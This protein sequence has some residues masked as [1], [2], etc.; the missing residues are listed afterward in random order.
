MFPFEVF[1]VPLAA[2]QADLCLLRH[3]TQK[4]LLFMMTQSL[5]DCKQILH[6]CVSRCDE[7]VYGFTE[8]VASCIQRAIETISVLGQRAEQRS[9]FLPQPE[10][11]YVEKDYEILLEDPTTE[12]VQTPTME[13]YLTHE[14]VPEIKV[15][16]QLVPRD[17]VEDPEIKVQTQIVLHDP[18]EDIE[19]E[20]PQDPDFLA[21]KLF[22][23]QAQID[24]IPTK[25]SYQELEIGESGQDSD[26]ASEHE[27]EDEQVKETVILEK[28]KTKAEKRRR[29]KER[30][31]LERQREKKKEPEFQVIVQTELSIS[32]RTESARR[33]LMLRHLFGV[34]S[35]DLRIRLE[36]IE[37]TIEHLFNQEGERK[38]EMK[39]PI[40]SLSQTRINLFKDVKEWAD[41]FQKGAL[42]LGTFRKFH[43]LCTETRRTIEE[44]RDIFVEYFALNHSED[45][46]SFSLQGEYIADFVYWTSVFK[47]CDE[48]IATDLL[49]WQ[50]EL[51]Q[52]WKEEK[53]KGS[54]DVSFYLLLERYNNVM[55]S[56]C[57]AA[58]CFCRDENCAAKL[59]A[60][61]ISKLFRIQ[62][63]SYVSH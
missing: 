53:R 62:P 44:N 20:D 58:N 40:R 43:S 9:L 34:L 21:M 19:K 49:K 39:K 41:C 23:A 29:Y 51:Q 8:D 3:K 60:P 48:W 33:L 42:S 35:N 36:G 55:G 22:P 52:M 45:I 46:I 27:N 59:V 18:E 6:H 31:R 4:K 11:E 57:Y 26:D 47:N 13:S 2:L 61:L 37:A 7:T 15:Q 1:A 28:T 32:S 63:F 14:L 24:P 56:S 50:P 30:K 25:N 12:A 17:P 54:D 38:C 16:T 10:V 5:N